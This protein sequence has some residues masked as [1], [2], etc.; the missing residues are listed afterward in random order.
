MIWSGSGRRHGSAATAAGCIRRRGG[1]TMATFRQTTSRAD[2]PQ[3]HTHAVISAK[4]QTADGRWLALDARFLKRHQRMLGGLYQ[5]ALRSELTARYGVAWDPIVNGQAELAGI[6]DELLAV[7]SKR[8]SQ[9]DAALEEKLV[10]FR[11]RH[12]RDPTRWE[13][14]ALTREAA[15]DTRSHK[16]GAGSGDLQQRWLTEAAEHG[17][18]PRRFND[19][20]AEHR[21]LEPPAAR[22]TVEQIVD[23]LSVGGSTWAR[24]DVLRTICDLTPPMPGHVRAA[25]DRGAGACLRSGARRVRQ[26]RPRRLRSGRRA[27]DGRSVWIEPVAPQYSS[28]QILAEEEHVIAWS[29]DAHETPGCSVGDG[30]RRPAWM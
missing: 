11:D 4:V 27:G 22:V 25:V 1:L 21:A 29:L 10:E 5:S 16:S 28:E 15:V 2:D 14:A 20:L 9:V 30:R 12:G 8:T 24:A 7:F 17:W 23:R 6:P 19:V 3:I 26:P 18:T 13:R